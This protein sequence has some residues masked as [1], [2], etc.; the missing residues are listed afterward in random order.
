MRDFSELERFRMKEDERILAAIGLL[1]ADG[2]VYKVFAGRRAFFCIASNGNGWD[3]VSV[4]MKNCKRN[5]C[6][7][8]EE[9]CE[10][11]DIFFL[12]EETVVQYHPPKSEYVND[13][14]TCLHLWRPNNGLVIPLPPQILV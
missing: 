12:P 8:W 3:H 4:T 14:E 9:M 2:G 13:Y 11:K 10:I 5:R 1:G 7:T 6:P